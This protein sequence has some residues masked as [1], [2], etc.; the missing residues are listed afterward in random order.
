MKLGRCRVAEA[1]R[2]NSKAVQVAGYHMASHGMMM[3]Q[4]RRILGHA[5]G[6]I[7]PWLLI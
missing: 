1:M 4:A 3:L 7:R 5:D 6:V 2:G